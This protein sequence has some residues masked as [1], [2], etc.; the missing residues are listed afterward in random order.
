MESAEA[1]V[2]VSPVVVVCFL[3]RAVQRPFDV[4][5]PKTAA[6]MLDH[7]VSAGSRADAVPVP[8]PSIPEAGWLTGMRLVSI[9]MFWYWC[10]NIE[11]LI[12]ASLPCASERH[13]TLRHFN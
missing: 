11:N 4:R 9:L 1:E 12:A 7:S 10:E 6:E 3:F 2:W 13:H 8:S 5:W